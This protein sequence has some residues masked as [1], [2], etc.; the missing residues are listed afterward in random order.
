M[1][2]HSSSASDSISPAGT[3]LARCNEYSLPTRNTVN[4]RPSSGQIAKNKGTNTAPGPSIPCLAFGDNRR[5]RSFTLAIV[6]V[7]L[8]GVL[9][10]AGDAQ[11]CKHRCDWKSELLHG[12]YSSFRDAQIVTKPSFAGAAHTQQS[13]RAF[14]LE[15]WCDLLTKGE[16]P[17]LPQIRTRWSSPGSPRVTK[18]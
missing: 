5:R 11:K 10:A 1:T 17:S 16:K 3:S 15:A 12:K 13:H 9:R 2:Y 6:P 8:P 18:P 4:K 14:C 7:V